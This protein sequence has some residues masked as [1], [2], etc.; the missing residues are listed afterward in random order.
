MNVVHSK[1][2]QAICFLSGPVTENAYL[3][4]SKTCVKI[5]NNFRKLPI[6]QFKAIRPSLKVSIDFYN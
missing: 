4:A 6:A 2:Y 1:R 3:I 5:A